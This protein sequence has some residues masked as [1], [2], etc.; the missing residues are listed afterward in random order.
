[1][2]ISMLALSVWAFN[3][4]AIDFFMAQ[5]FAAYNHRMWLDLSKS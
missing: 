3:Q 2:G 4:P 1:M 5:G